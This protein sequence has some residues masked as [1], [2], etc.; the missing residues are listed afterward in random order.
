MATDTP[1]K[2][3]F[4]KVTSVGWDAPIYRLYIE[5]SPDDNPC[6]EDL[7]N[8]VALWV[9]SVVRVRQLRK[10]AETAKLKEAE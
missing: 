10:A 8:R 1:K 7:E 6:L 4:G 5:V 2:E 3:L 9:G